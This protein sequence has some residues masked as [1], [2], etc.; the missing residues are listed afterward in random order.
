[1]SKK[2]YTSLYETKESLQKYTNKLKELMCESRRTYIAIPVKE[3][4]PPEGKWVTTIDIDDNERVYRFINGTWN[5]R[6]ADGENSPNN[7]LEI[8]LWL[9]RQD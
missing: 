3:R 9:E 1:M 4:M 2:K 5:M 7:N 8:T 6:D